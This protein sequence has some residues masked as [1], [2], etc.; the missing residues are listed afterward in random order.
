MNDENAQ[1][2][3]YNHGESV[4]LLYH[5]GQSP[6]WPFNRQIIQSEFSS[7]LN[8]VSLTRSTTSSDWKLFIFNKMEVNCFQILLIDVTYYH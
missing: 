8:C 6:V 3:M 1:S 5:K 4:G 2:G 7:T